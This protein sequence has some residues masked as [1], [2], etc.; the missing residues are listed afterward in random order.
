[1]IKVYSTNVHFATQ[2]LSVRQSRV[3]EALPRSLLS[4][5]GCKA[6]GQGREKS[7]PC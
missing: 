6:E 4:F 1:M 5:S 7:L 2:C 3:A